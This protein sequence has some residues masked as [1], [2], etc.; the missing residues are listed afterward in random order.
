MPVWRFLFSFSEEEAEFCPQVIGKWSPSPTPV[1]SLAWLIF[2][3]LS[4]VIS[5]TLESIRKCHLCTYQVYQGPYNMWCQNETKS[6]WVLSHYSKLSLCNNVQFAEIANEIYL[7]MHCL[8]KMTFKYILIQIS[9]CS[10]IIQCRN[11]F[12]ILSSEDEQ[13]EIALPCEGVL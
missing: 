3:H 11:L 6:A 7:E 8:S 4:S 13:C 10:F 1:C 5:L 12:C 2:G 9:H